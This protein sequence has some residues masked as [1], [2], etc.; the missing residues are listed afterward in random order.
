[1]NKF[2]DISKEGKKFLS[3][4]SDLKDKRFV[5]YGTGRLTERLLPMI[6]DKFN[7][8]ALM[9]SDETIIG[10]TKYDLPVVSLSEAEEKADI[11][12]INTAE[13]YW[14]AIY[15]RIAGTKLPVYYTNGY[16]A[17]EKNWIA[18]TRQWYTEYCSVENFD[19]EKRSEQKK[20]EALVIKYFFQNI[21][22]TYKTDEQII[23]NSAEDYGYCL[24]GPVILTFFIWLINKANTYDLEELLF[25][26]RDGY[27]LIDEYR[28]FIK[29][30]KLDRAP[31]AKYIAGSRRMILVAG[32]CDEESF[33]EVAT[34][35]FSGTFAGY[36]KN[37]FFISVEGKEGGEFIILPRDEKKVFS[38]MQP[39]MQ[40]IQQE[41][42]LERK[43][44]LRYLKRQNIGKKVGVVDTGYSGRLP[45][46]LGKLLQL[47]IFP[48]FY[49]YG[50]MSDQNIYND[51]KQIEACFQENN[52]VVA[53]G[54]QLEKHR[55][56]NESI[57]TAPYGMM[58]RVKGEEI[59]YME[60]EI[61]FGV[62]EEINVG[63]KRFLKDASKVLSKQIIGDSQKAKE[64]ALWA[65]GF[66]G[67]VYQNTKLSSEQQKRIKYSD[68]WFGNS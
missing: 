63:I 56:L 6:R 17:D 41:I 11:I 46:H 45:Y 12:I 65:D 24:Y 3:R 61:D 29:L 27:L 48:T 21:C 50:D 18:K 14:N 60:Q 66:F 33:K 39:Y 43:D 67:E 57:F 53:K 36:M 20:L 37:R 23:Y 16:R 64:L 22:V 44:Y 26:A 5:L 42:E 68:G 54:C 19:V 9:D 58:Q 34:H 49:W 32:I 8:V 62:N 28:E 51:A 25:P 59:C 40:E 31:V 4:F 35:T 1:M 7:I 2:D 47:E 52:D 55:I 13:I 10:F 38:M 30:F 15:E